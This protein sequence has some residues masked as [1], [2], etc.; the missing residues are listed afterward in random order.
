MELNSWEKFKFFFL[1]YH[2]IIYRVIELEAQ[3]R[4]VILTVL[5]G[6]ANS[7]AVRQAGMR[8]ED[9]HCDWCR[10]RRLKD[11][12]LPLMRRVKGVA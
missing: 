9:V 1:F 4:E 8:M 6:G 12:G 3:W 10:G 2:S 7:E 11:L 5:A